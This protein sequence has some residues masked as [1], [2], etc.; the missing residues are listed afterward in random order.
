MMKQQL[1][2]L[3]LEVKEVK[4][5]GNCAF[6]AIADQLAMDEEKHPLYRKMACDLMEKNKNDYAN[7]ITDDRTIEDHI[8]IMREAK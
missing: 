2:T 8:Q 7:F 6:R 4:A 3:G 5:D 1:S